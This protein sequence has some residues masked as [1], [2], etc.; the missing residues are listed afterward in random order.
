MKIIF[1][2][3]I[4]LPFVYCAM[5]ELAKNSSL[6]YV[7]VFAKSEELKVKA[8]IVVQKFESNKKNIVYFDDILLMQKLIDPIKNALTADI[9]T[10]TTESNSSKTLDQLIAQY[11]NNE[12]ITNLNIKF[13]KLITQFDVIEKIATTSRPISCII[14]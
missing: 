14:L 4:F 11:E 2:T 7:V 8:R 6:G 5:N 12:I 10:I 3:L 1:L 13:D 9:K